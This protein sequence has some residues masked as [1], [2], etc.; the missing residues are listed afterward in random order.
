[1][2]VTAAG[3]HLLSGIINGPLAVFYTFKLGLAGSKTSLAV[4]IFA[5]WNTVNDPIL[6]ILEDK[7]RTRLGRRIPYLRYGAPLFGLL[8]VF[9]WFP[10]LDLVIADRQWALFANLL[11]SLFLFDTIFTLIGLVTYALPAE[12]CFTR[13]GRTDLQVYAIYLGGLGML[14]SMVITNIFLS[15]TAST[16]SPWFRPVM[17]V[18]AL[19]GSLMVFIPSFILVENEYA[20]TEKKPTLLRSIRETF[21]N[22]QFL[23]FEFGNFFYQIAWV[24]L[25]GLT[26]PFVGYVLGFEGLWSTIPLFAVFL[27]AFLSVIPASRVVRI[28]GNKKTYMAALF[29]SIV[30]FIALFLSSGENSTVALV[31]M[32]LLGV[33][34]APA[35][36]LN[37]PLYFEV[38]DKDEIMTG[39]RRETTYAGM[40]AL[41]VK[42]AIGAANALFFRVVGMFGFV[43]PTQSVPD[44]TQPESAIVGIRLAYTLIP[45]AALLVRLFFMAFYTLDG[46]EWDKQKAQLSRIHRQKEREYVAKL[47]KERKR[48]PTYSKL[49]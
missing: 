32:A 2:G 5:I 6:G 15:R 1:F 10:F 12:M 27:A 37:A 38:I 23:V 3:V 43:E 24:V 7:T 45:A 21:K 28:W 30:L 39:K 40:N 31:V 33:S 11:L 25:T 4:L 47:A 17:V 9:C 16:M 49:R 34:Y 36:L 44:P 41:F 46:A 48:S 19:F 18:T 26:A 35:T 20:V 13:R 8:F 29:L 14:G 42:P 22:G